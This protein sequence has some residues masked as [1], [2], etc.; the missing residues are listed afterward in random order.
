MLKTKLQNYIV[1]YTNKEEYHILKNEIF[2]NSS[3]YFNIKNEKPTIIDCGSHIGLSLIYFKEISPNAKIIA[4]EPNPEVLNILKQ[5]IFENNLTNI[6]VI[7]K[8]LSTDNSPKEFFFDSSTD[9]WYSTGSFRQGSWQGVQKSKR[10]LVDCI[11]LSSLI[12]EKTDILKLDI[13]GMEEK[14]LFEAKEK[15][16]LVENIVIEYHPIKGNSFEKIVGLL[17]KSKFRVKL[18]LEGKEV[19][20]YREKGLIIIKATR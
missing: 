3:Y 11:T 14:V 12:T 6:E 7:P 8:A 15:L 17:K 2:I 5:N 13:E 10:I 20:E 9:N 1:N 19:K 4:V 18:F 16:S